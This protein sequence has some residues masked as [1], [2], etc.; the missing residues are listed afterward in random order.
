MFFS[1][2]FIPVGNA[3]IAGMEDVSKK[4]ASTNGRA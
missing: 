1:L 3:E 4:H 2:S